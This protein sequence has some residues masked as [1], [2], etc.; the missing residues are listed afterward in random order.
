M[1]GDLTYEDETVLLDGEPI[2]VI[3]SDVVYDYYRR[4]HRERFFPMI[5]SDRIG[6]DRGYRT[7]DAAAAKLAAR[8][9]YLTRT[10][11]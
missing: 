10:E 9:Q 7:R 5:G 8:H 1:S 4:D 11:N 6:L 3:V 2:G